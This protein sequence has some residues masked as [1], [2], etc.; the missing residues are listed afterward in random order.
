MKK[1]KMILRR[2]EIRPRSIQTGKDL[3]GVVTYRFFTRRAAERDCGFLNV[4]RRVFGALSFE[5][6]IADRRADA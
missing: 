5:Y 3:E 1:K 4:Q 2:Y 6:Y